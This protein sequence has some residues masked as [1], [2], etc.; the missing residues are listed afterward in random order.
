M[1][2][3]LLSTLV[4]ACSA[5]SAA[6]PADQVIR[7]RS[8]DAS[9]A[10]RPSEK[11]C[12]EIAGPAMEPGALARLKGIVTKDLAERGLELGDPAAGAACDAT[13][14]ILLL[15]QRI[16]R[17]GRVSVADMRTSLSAIQGASAAASAPEDPASGATAK[18]LRIES[19]GGSTR[20]NIGG[21]LIRAGTLSLAVGNVLEFAGVSGAFNEAV[22][23]D[24]RGFNLLRNPYWDHYYH[25][26]KIEARIERLKDAGPIGRIK[27]SVL[28]FS[29]EMDVAAAFAVAWD[30]FASA[31]VEKPAAPAESASGATQ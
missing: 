18:R 9:H 21:S 5:A 22:A 17:K 15:P 10:L 8:T 28:L 25:F 19:Y 6:E 16:E 14:S 24:A 30:D 26:Q 1:K 29:R 23:G 4:L 27:T 3:L 31:I 11:G 7:N 13:V 20:L 12:L 2:P